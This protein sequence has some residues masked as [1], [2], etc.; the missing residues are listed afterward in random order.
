MSFKV[1]KIIN[2]DIVKLFELLEM[3]MTMYDRRCISD[4]VIHLDGLTERQKDD[5]L[6]IEI[7]Y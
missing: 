3:L 1:V 2:V 6:H 7:E 4:G 5:I